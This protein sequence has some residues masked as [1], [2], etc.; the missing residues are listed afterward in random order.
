MDGG[1]H[2]QQIQFFIL[3]AVR[4]PALPRSPSKN[5]TRRLRLHSD[6]LKTLKLNY[7]CNFLPSPHF[8]AFCLLHF[9]RR[10]GVKR[11][12]CAYVFEMLKWCMAGKP[13]YNS[14]PIPPVFFSPFWTFGSMW[15]CVCCNESAIKCPLS[16]SRK[17]AEMH[18]SHSKLPTGSLEYGQMERGKG[19]ASSCLWRA[20]RGHLGIY[21]GWEKVGFKRE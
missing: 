15:V 10:L 13:D 2:R 18:F 14:M 4:L 21:S 12:L 19:A 16:F 17:P 9:C 3:R 1:E 5:T 8:G 6:S 11:F 20:V 7:N